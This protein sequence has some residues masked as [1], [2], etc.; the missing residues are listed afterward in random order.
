[1]PEP[2]PKE[3][4]TFIGPSVIISYGEHAKKEAVSEYSLDV[5]KSILSAAGVRH[6]TITSTVRNSKEQA[7]V[8]YYNLKGTGKGQ[9]VDNQKKLYGPRGRRVIDLYVRLK[10]TQGVED[11]ETIIDSMRAKIDKLCPRKVSKHCASPSDLKTL[12]VID[13][14]PSSIPDDKKERLIEKIKKDSRINQNHFFQPPRDPG[15]HI[16]IPQ[17]PLAQSG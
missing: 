2:K 3:V 4:G 12:N 13:I 7:Q 10:E 1:M 14:G 5:I 16:E 9:G 15:Y 17:P 8:M 11:E 6:A